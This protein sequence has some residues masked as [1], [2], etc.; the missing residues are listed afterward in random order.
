MTL[1][2][3]GGTI[4]F[5]GS[6]G[7]TYENDPS[8]C[9]GLA[10]GGPIRNPKDQRSQT[11]G[12]VKHTYRRDGRPIAIAGRLRVRSAGTDPEYYE[13]RQTLKDALETALDSILNTGGTLSWTPVGETNPREIEVFYDVD[14]ETPFESQTVQRY[15]FVLYAPDPEIT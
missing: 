10:G 14:L 9:G 4:Q 11:D 5:N 15:V 2:T 8:A 12:A 6:T 13:A 7:D 3:G 1:T